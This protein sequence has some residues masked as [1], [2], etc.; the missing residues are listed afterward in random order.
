[1][2][3]KER[4]IMKISDEMIFELKERGFIKRNLVKPDYRGF[5]ISN[6]APTILKFLDIK[7]EA[8]MPLQE[9]KIIK[10]AIKNRGISDHYDNI[11]LLNSLEPILF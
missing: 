11:I 10:K 1:M 9:M 4:N 8:S 6:I 7:F 2:R 5:C 3:N